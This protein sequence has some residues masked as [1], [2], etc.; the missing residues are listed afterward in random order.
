[1]SNNFNTPPATAN[2]RNLGAALYPVY[3]QGPTFSSYLW[4]IDLIHDCAVDT[5]SM[6]LRAALATYA[7]YDAFTWIAQDRQIFQG[8]NEPLPT[9]QRRLVQWLDIWRHAGSSTALMLATL[10]YL[11]PLAPQ[12]ATV[13]SSGDGTIS[14]WDT[15]YA[16]SAPFPAGQTQPT[17]PYHQVVT[18]NWNW[19]GLAPPFYYSWMS[20]R[21]WLI[22][23]SNGSQAP[24]SAPTA[25]WAS[26]GTFALAVASDPN[27]GTVYKNGGTP[28]S[29]SATSFAWGDR[30][31][32]WGWSGTASQA[33]GLEQLCAEWK[34]AGCW[35][36]WIIVCYD[37]AHLQSNSVSA[38]LPAGLWGYA[39]SVVV[40]VTYLSRYAN[41]RPSP[42][43]C[44]LIC[45]TNDGGG[46]LGIG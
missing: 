41:G 36:P 28:A 3:M 9:Y 30:V 20:W 7:P 38:D 10:A 22:I 35:I 5:T 14:T 27:Y 31:T 12:I 16:G 8:P 18:A 33:L 15:Y 26:G 1:M 19:D 25:T 4:S 21:K 45:G 46:V 40:D 39:S 2:L 29:G 34:S 24:W 11:F 42:A 32:C 17:P 44:T 23:Q 13:Q 43:I 6:A 37:A